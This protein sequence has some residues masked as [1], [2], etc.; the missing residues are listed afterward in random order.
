MK[1]LLVASLL[2]VSVPGAVSAQSLGEVAAKARA[3][4]VAACETDP[5][6]CPVVPAPLPAVTVLTDKDVAPSPALLV[7]QT[8]IAPGAAGTKVPT[9]QIETWRTDLT[10]YEGDQRR[11]QAD[12]DY[13]LR[14][15]TVSPAAYRIML[16]AG[17]P[18]L[19]TLRQVIAALRT[20][21]A[22]AEITNATK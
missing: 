18:L 2:V 12:L 3:A 20:S 11:V 8:P 6:T 7:I 15:P 17:T 16:R 10:R 21:I 14:S 22:D 19:E 1:T 5:S 9:W 4:R 13:G